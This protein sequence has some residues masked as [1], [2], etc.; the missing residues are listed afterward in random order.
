MNYMHYFHI[1]FIH[2]KH[3][4]ICK[5]NINIFTDVNDLWSHLLT[6]GG[7]GHPGQVRG[8][9]KP[10]HQFMGIWLHLSR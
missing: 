4:H 6:T 7:E 2:Y 8:V 1:F 10:R 3:L 9:G 5:H